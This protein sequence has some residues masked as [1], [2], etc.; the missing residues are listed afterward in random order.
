[1]PNLFLMG[2]QLLWLDQL[3]SG[4][5][6][7]AQIGDVVIVYLLTGSTWYAV[8]KA[9]THQQSVQFEQYAIEPLTV[10]PG[11]GAWLDQQTAQLMDAAGLTR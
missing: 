7:A 6:V 8:T 9:M 10:G 4:T 11:L 1:M 5:R 2:A 3:L